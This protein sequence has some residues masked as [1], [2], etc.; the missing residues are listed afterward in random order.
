[1]PLMIVNGINPGHTVSIT[2]GMHSTEFAGIEAATRTYHQIN[3][4]TFNGKLLIVP[5]VNTVAFQRGTIPYI[6]PLDNQNLYNIFPGD[7]YGSISYR[8][9]YTLFTKVILR[10]QF[11]IDCHGG[12]L[13]EDLPFYCNFAY[14]TGNSHVDETS[15]LMARH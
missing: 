6:N 11:Y 4:L 7:P 12:D 5:V 2:A 9:I 14:G 3:P 13:G 8:M 1:M 10:A 15:K